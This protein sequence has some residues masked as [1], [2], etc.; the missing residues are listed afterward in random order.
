MAFVLRY[1]TLKQFRQADQA[2]KRYVT[3][4]PEDTYMRGIL[5]RIEARNP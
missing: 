4:F 1:V 2:L 5:A 3:L